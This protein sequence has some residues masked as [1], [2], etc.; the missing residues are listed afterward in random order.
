[1]RQ[2]EIWL[3]IPVLG[4][5]VEVFKHCFLASI[6]NPSF[7]FTYIQNFQDFEFLSLWILAKF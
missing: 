6:Y 3:T 4:R 5:K 2:K 7:F 1:M